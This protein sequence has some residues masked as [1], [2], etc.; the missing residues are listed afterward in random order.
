M[1]GQGR[2]EEV[3]EAAAWDFSTRGYAATSFGSIA[4]RLGMAR[5]NVQ[6]YITSKPDLAAEIAWRPFH[7]GV[8]LM[9]GTEL[10]GGVPMIRDMVQWVAH[11]YVNDVFA[12]AS[13]RLMDERALVPADLPVPFTGWIEPITSL[14]DEA[15]TSGD[16]A[17]GTDTADLA[18]RMVSSFAGNRLVC[19]VIGDLEAL[20]Q[21]AG[22]TIDDLLRA[23]AAG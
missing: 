2:R 8:F 15:V 23:N 21:L 7:A 1:S 10:T 13:M 14:L 16:I 17:P 9:P 20:P 19:E 22:R 18:R 5:G 11:H 12:R 6:Y 4:E 3:L